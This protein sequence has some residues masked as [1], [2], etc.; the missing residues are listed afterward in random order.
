[1]ERAR[2]EW[3]LAR[4]PVK[5]VE[6][7]RS[8]PAAGIDVF[9]PEEIRALCRAAAD[10]QDAALYLTAAS[11]AAAAAS[12]A[13][14]S[15]SGRL[16]QGAGERAAAADRRSLAGETSSGAPV[17]GATRAIDVAMVATSRR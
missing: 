10:E 4:N 15:P 6:K 12:D 2:R 17:S 3:K 7:P 8:A 5:D 1:M 11:S 9:S 13:C 16:L 14:L